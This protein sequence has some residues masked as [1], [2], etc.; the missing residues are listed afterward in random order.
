VA[1]TYPVMLTSSRAVLLVIVLAALLRLWFL[2]GIPLVI[3]NDGV[4]YLTWGVMILE[5]QSVE[6]PVFRTPGYPLFLALV[7]FLAGISPFAVLVAQHLLGIA[8]CGLIAWTSSRLAGPRI[9]LVFGI[10]AALDPWLLGFSSY[11]LSEVLA[12]FLMV[13]TVSVM[14]SARRA[15][16]T[17]ALVLGLLMAAMVLV[18]PAFQI[19]VPFILL[20]WLVAFAPRSRRALL[21]TSA[22]AASFLLAL[23]PW[24]WHNHQRGITGVSSGTSA[25]LWMGVAEAQLLDNE[26]PVPEYIQAP[27]E[28]HVRGNWSNAGICTFLQDVKAWRNR[29]S[30]RILHEWAVHSIRSNQQ[31]WGRAFRYAL[32]WQLG[33]FPK[34]GPVRNNHTQW[35]LRRLSQDGREH[36]QAHVNFQFDEGPDVSR[37]AMHHEPGPQRYYFSTVTRWRKLGLIHAAFLGLAV[38]VVL[39]AIVR[40][41]WM[42]AAA[43]MATIAFYMLHAVFLFPE[44]RYSLP[45]WM[46]WY[47]APAALVAVIR[48]ASRPAKPPPTLAKRAINDLL[49]GASSRD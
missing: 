3:T 40:G 10:L 8:T 13:L 46:A 7:Y 35:L 22:M 45:S 34:G 48:G 44:S 28:R 25:F 12:T 32:V 1:I 24:L 21:T 14:L 18:R 41:R 9:A 16:F 31:E 17:G 6:W 49:A 38:I 47:L 20:G 15:T 27:Y 26:F 19:A 30:S 11:A 33:Y 29:E 36:G 2:A 37:F 43:F 42:I 23:A 4:G 5:G 39:L